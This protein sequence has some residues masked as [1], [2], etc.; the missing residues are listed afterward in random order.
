MNLGY[1][2][3]EVLIDKDHSSE[4]FNRVMIEPIEPGFGITL[5]N[6]LR[7]VL[8]KNM[9]GV[10]VVA[11]RIKGVNHEL[12]SIP[13]T[14][15]DTI[16]LISALKKV[17]FDYQGHEDK[18]VAIK[19]DKNGEVLAGDFNTSEI[20]VKTPEIVLLRSLGEKSFEVE[21]FLRKFRGFVEA[22]K[23]MDIPEGFVKMDGLFSPIKKVGYNVSNMMVDQEMSHER[24]TMDVETD[25]T[26]EAKEAILLASK[27][28]REH[29]TMFDH[30]KEKMTDYEVFKQQEKERESIDN[31]SIEELQL[32]VRSTNALKAAGVKN[33]GELRKIKETEI[34]DFKNMGVTSIKEVKEKLREIGA[35]LGDYS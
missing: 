35:E 10:A 3:I 16:E 24:L 19:V 6:S 4:F 12:M 18:I 11:F 25:G 2:E 8:L 33:V 29:F 27:I 13:Y 26:I 5:G 17:R 30:M 15:T 22:G 1:R 28:V 21:L 14:S 31:T 7:R 34:K 23:H 32:S 9:P 20:T